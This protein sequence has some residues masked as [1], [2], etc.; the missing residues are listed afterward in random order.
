MSYLV[1]VNH[2]K[3]YFPLKKG[4]FSRH[5][6]F[7]CAVDNVSFGISKGETLGLVGESGCGKTTIGR[8]IMKLI[9]PTSGN[10]FFDSNNL[11][12]LNPK[13][14]RE[15][16]KKIAL[17][18]QD[19]YS[20][21]NPRMQVRDIIAEPLT[22]HTDIKNSQLRDKVLELLSYVGMGK[23]HM[24]RYPHQF[25][26]GQLQRISVARALAL[27]PS[28]MVLDE[29]TSALDVSVQA[30]VLN[31]LADLQE[32]FNLTYL[33]ISHNLSVVEHISHRVAIMYLGRIVE[34]GPTKNIFANPLHP[35]AKALLSAVPNP[36]P[37]HQ[38]EEVILTGDVPSPVNIP[39]GCRFHTRCNYKMP[40]CQRIE[41]DL[42]E[43]EPGHEVACHLY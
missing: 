38:Q 9:E 17:V 36:D 35:Y 32:T 43:K 18:F 20:S 39:E 28:F 27:N 14:L 10:A 24:M 6:D 15:I 29:P 37:D 21:L 5:K 8:T 13:K 1:E 3:K 41:P 33:F 11:F 25:S 40:I 7:V 26:G 22:T 42:K 12:L 16:R 31:L 4:V 23:E 30:Q 34:M 2:L 19:P